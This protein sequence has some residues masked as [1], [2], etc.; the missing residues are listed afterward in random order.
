MYSC[1]PLNLRSTVLAMN[2]QYVKK[3]TIE[4]LCF[5]SSPKVANFGHQLSRSKC[6]LI[7]ENCMKNLAAD[8]FMA[9]NLDA[10]IQK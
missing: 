6:S 1:F 10:T 5:L 9:D 8:I 4:H 2:A 3:W 7:H